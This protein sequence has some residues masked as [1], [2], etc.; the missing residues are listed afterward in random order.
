MDEPS[1]PLCRPYFPSLDELTPHLKEILSSRYLTNGGPY[2][3]RLEEQL[4][5]HLGVKHLS[6]VANGTLGL[7]LA[8]RAHGVTGEVITTPFSFVATS[9]SILWTGLTPVFVDID[10]STLNIDPDRVERAI[11][12]ATTAI[13]PV[14]CFGRPCDANALQR[15]AT[16]HGLKLLFD[17]AH[18]FGVPYEGSS[19]LLRGDASV[20]SFHAT[21]AF[22]T[23]EG[24]AVISTSHEDKERIDRMRNFGIEDEDS[25]TCEG[26][27]A[28]LD[29][30]N[31]LVGLLHL[32]HIDKL[33]ACRSMTG[34]TYR[35]ELEGIPG[36]HC[37]PRFTGDNHS[38]FPI[39]LDK[40]YPLSSRELQNELNQRNICNRR[41]FHPLI[42]N[43]PMYQ[44]LPSAAPANLPGANS[45]ADKIICLPI[46][47]ELSHP[48]VLRITEL[49]RSLSSRGGTAV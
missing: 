6:I 27:N 36:L 19:V 12:T 17:A 33:M 23:I 34:E 30:M 21:K 38:Y 1:I 45:V 48:E 42:S 4:S 8:L 16:T 25:I 47:A 24:G 13:L 5:A 10:P 43:L 18:A 40:A 22:H 39:L 31:A 44:H 14:H 2:V 28:K 11:T 41:Y 3:C 37:L 49:L 20:L 15:L 29:E 26:I 9:H 35:K 7:L 32:R 46:H